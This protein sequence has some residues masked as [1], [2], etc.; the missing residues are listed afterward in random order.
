M[1]PIDLFNASIERPKHILRLYD[2]L[3]D[4]RSRSVRRDWAKSFKEMMRWPKGED[5]VRV[6]GKDK[7]SLLIMR[8]AVGIDRVHFSHDYL[9]ELL[10][11]VVVAAISSL[12]RYL[13]DL[14]VHHSWKLLSK[15]DED[16]PTELKKL[17]IPVSVAKRAIQQLKKDAKARPG[18]IVKKA[19][20][21]RL[22]RE[23]T[24]QKPD[25]VLKA[26]KMLGLE[27][28]WT[29]VASKMPGTPKK[30][31]VVATLR[32]IA[33]RRNEIVHEA[34]LVLKTKAREITLRDITRA[35]AENWINWMEE[36]VTAI[37]QVADASI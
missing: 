17:S 29:K 30:E 20:Q 1:K 35:D 32:T 21:E 31:D 5:I 8:Q 18:H 6:D 27:D 28:F 16:V 19:I 10:R 4:S 36:F 34:D 12:D 22:H 11:S 2:L 24:F 23:Y 13:H 37:D 3:H 26:S 33:K 15:A 25:D 7:Q 14:V 9:S